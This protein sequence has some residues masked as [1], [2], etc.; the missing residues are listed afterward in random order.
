MA[1][2][3]LEKATFWFNAVNMK[4]TMLAVYRQT[5]S[6]LAQARD[7]LEKN[8]P[9]AGQMCD[10]YAQQAIMH[11]RDLIIAQKLYEVATADIMSAIEDRDGGEGSP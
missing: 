6:D 9:G 11:E 7:H 5:Q 8:V 4:E 2:S 1:N 10:G 3:F